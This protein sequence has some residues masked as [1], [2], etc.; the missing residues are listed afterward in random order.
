MKEYFSKLVEIANQIRILGE[1]LLDQ[2]VVDKILVIL[3]DKF[4]KKNS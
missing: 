1:K 2:K 4:E 3:L